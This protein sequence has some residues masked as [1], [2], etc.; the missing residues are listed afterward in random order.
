MPSNIIGNPDK[1]KFAVMKEG[2][3]KQDATKMNV[4]KVKN[5]TFENNLY[6][7]L[8]VAMCGCIF[9]KQPVLH[10]SLRWVGLTD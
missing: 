10:H 2:Y 5:I 7:I 3:G 6:C 1:L 8:L 4:C 9:R